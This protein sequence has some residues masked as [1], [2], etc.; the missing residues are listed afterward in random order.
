MRSL[1][2]RLTLATCLAVAIPSA[3][4]TQQTDVTDDS[5]PKITL[6]AQPNVGATPARIVLTAEL[7]GGTDDFEEYYC[8]TV[9]WDWDDDTR[10]E[11]TSDCEPYA[12]GKSEIRRRYTVEHVFRRGGV[13]RVYIRLKQR[14]KV[15]GSSTVSVTIRARAP[16]Y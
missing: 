10:S 15:V 7:V 11:S 5:R 6:R 9:E 1:P 12:A 4:L 2:R 13:F 16:Y 3:V 14:D 8:P